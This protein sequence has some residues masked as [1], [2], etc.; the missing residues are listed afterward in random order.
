MTHIFEDLVL[1]KFEYTVKELYWNFIEPQ[2]REG[3][4]TYLKCINRLGYYNNE[5][6]VKMLVWNL[7]EPH[8]Q[9]APEKFMLTKSK[10]ASYLI[11][12]QH[13]IKNKVL[14]KINPLVVG[15]YEPNL[16]SSLYFIIVMGS[17][18][19]KPK[20]LKKENNR[21]IQCC[22]LVPVRIR[23][24]VPVFNMSRRY[25]IS[26]MIPRYMADYL[27][28]IT[29]DDSQLEFIS[30]IT[31]VIDTIIITLDL[32]AFIDIYC[33][34]QSSKEFSLL[35]RDNDTHYTYKPYKMYNFTNTGVLPIKNEIGSNCVLKIE[36]KT[37]EVCDL[38]LN[39]INYVSCFTDASLCM[40]S[41]CEL[42]ND[43]INQSI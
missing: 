32:S 30:S 29:I 6:I 15:H 35:T 16:S 37:D 39:K 7:S 13:W 43:F 19:K 25:T 34:E 5:D 2:H 18:H 21:N 14:Q 40:P 10:T 31:V 8:T 38:D 28:G 24:I 4:M 23:S 1:P 22:H 11:Y 26:Q 42:E 41:W 9:Y 33:V 17:T 36:C 20:M 12:S 3:F 27:F